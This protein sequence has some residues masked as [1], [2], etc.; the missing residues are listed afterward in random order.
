[1]NLES[2]SKN[3]TLTPGYRDSGGKDSIKLTKKFIKSLVSWA[4]S[5]SFAATIDGYWILQIVHK[6]LNDDIKK[7]ALK[8][9]VLINP[10]RADMIK[11]MPRQTYYSDH[12]LEKIED[13]YIV[14]E[15]S[16]VFWREHEE[17]YQ[18]WI[19]NPK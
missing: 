19:R 17:K 2:K 6:D 9:K 16:E 8:Q 12:Y 18:E 11:Y 5:V 1:M 10:T 15:K 14:V 7:Y 4:K 3:F 13:G